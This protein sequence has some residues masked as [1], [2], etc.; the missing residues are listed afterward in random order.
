MHAIVIIFG[1]I[2]PVFWLGVG[3]CLLWKRTVSPKCLDCMSLCRGFPRYG[4]CKGFMSRSKYEPEHT[5]KCP[6]AET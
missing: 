5:E 2:I 1:I 4:Y 3:A 6:V